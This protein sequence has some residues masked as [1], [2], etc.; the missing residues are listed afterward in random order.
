[1]EVRRHP[2]DKVLSSGDEHDEN[3][4]KRSRKDINIL[5]ISVDFNDINGGTVHKFNYESPHLINDCLII[6]N[7]IISGS[8][9]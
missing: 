9:S 6:V 8:N 2:G 1:V 3:N 4:E 5:F 7:C